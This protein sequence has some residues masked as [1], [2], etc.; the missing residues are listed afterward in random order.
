MVLDPI[1]LFPG[2][3]AYLPGVFADLANTHRSVAETLSSVDRA[4]RRCGNPSVTNILT[5]RSALPLAD[6]VRT[7][8]RS[9]HL[10]I[11]TIELALFKLL[12]EEVGVEPAALVGHSFGELVALTAAEIFS[13]EDGVSLVIARDDALAKCPPPAGGMLAVATSAV[14]VRHLLEALSEWNVTIAAENGSN[15]TVVSG[16]DAALSRMEQAA[17]AIG[18]QATRLN[19]A[20][21]FHH[22]SLAPAAKLF[23]EAASHLPARP[24]RYRVISSILGREVDTPEDAV[25]LVAAHLTRPTRFEGCLLD[26]QARGRTA[27]IECGARSILCGL[28]SEVLPRAKV[29]A[30][31]G[32]R[33][34]ATDVAAVVAEYMSVQREVDDLPDDSRLSTPPVP[35]SVV[36]HSRSASAL[37]SDETNA[38]NSQPVAPDGASDDILARLREMY[39]DALG[40]PASVFTAHADLEADLGIDSIKR[41]ELI[42]RAAARFGRDLPRTGHRLTAY[43]TLE[44]VVEFIAQLPVSAGTA[45]ETV[46]S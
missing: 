39:G 1:F 15:Q 29:L 7:D 18:I 36:L 42:S 38:S 8:P 27:F 10:A 43:T 24:P 5:D 45:Q 17:V 21:P 26:L 12:T 9:L 40:Y 34:T 44:S 20:Y 22:R 46:L 16:P 14:R 11:F 28:V 33:A 37:M 31:L 6:L 13:L 41:T 30:P 23:A 25:T 35:S 4:A 19:A 2:Q 3:G 32:S